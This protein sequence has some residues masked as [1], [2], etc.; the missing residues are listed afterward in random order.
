[1]KS[2]WARRRRWVALIAVHLLVAGISLKCGQYDSVGHGPYLLQVPRGGG[3]YQDAVN[4][5][6]FLDEEVDDGVMTGWI[7]GTGCDS[8]VSLCNAGL[9]E[10]VFAAWAGPV[11]TSFVVYSED[12]YIFDTF[13]ENFEVCYK[14]GGEWCQEMGSGQSWSCTNSDEDIQIV[15]EATCAASLLTEMEVEY[16]DERTPFRA[17]FATY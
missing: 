16:F 8:W 7:R 17:C 13:L 12:S 15:F 3:L 14:D 5:D 9:C 4:I 1:M 10:T 6:F 2:K 11:E